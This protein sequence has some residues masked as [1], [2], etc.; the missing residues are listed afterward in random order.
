V[1]VLTN[2]ESDPQ[3]EFKK[4]RRSRCLYDTLKEAGLKADRK[5]GVIH[6]E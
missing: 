5:R 4:V 3:F 1:I 2:D 6:L